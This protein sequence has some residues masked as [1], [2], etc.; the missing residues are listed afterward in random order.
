MLTT[1]EGFEKKGIWEEG[2]LVQPS[3]ENNDSQKNNKKCL[4]FWFLFD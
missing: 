1:Q 2:E 3:D 4:I